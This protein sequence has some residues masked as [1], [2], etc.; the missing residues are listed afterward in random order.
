MP[1][2][3]IYFGLVVY[4]YSNEHEPIHVHGEFQGHEAKAEIILRHGKITEIVFSNVAGKPP[5]DRAKFKDF[6]NLVRVKAD[7]IVGRWIDYFVKHIHQKPEL[8][9]RKLK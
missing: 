5:L 2:L 4:F 7:E 3:Y 1:K 8:I 6:K 9:T